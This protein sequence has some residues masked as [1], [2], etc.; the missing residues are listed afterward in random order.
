MG[1]PIPFEVEIE[2][3]SKPQPSFNKNF[4]LLIEDLKGNT[5][6]GLKNYIFTDN[7]KQIER[8]YAIFEDLDANVEFHPIN[9]AIHQGFLDHEL[10]IACY[11]D[12]QIFERFHRYK[13]KKG[14]T[15]DLAINL[16]MLRR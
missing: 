12:H 14:F 13:L 7:P 5:S 9:K 15:K 8:F 16:K 6:K 2:Y 4:K 11:T 3:N 10:K 1:F